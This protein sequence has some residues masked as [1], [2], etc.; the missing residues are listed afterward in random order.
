MDRWGHCS[1]YYTDFATHT[2]FF[3]LFLHPLLFSVLLFFHLLTLVEIL[4]ENHYL[5]SI[6][7]VKDF[8]Y[9]S[10]L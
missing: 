4:Q 10:I 5:F 6:A 2:Y 3:E 1:H 9:Y 7:L 8:R